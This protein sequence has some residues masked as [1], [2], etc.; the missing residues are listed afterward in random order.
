MNGYKIAIGIDRNI[1][2]FPVMVELEIPEYATVVKPNR[3]FV[4]KNFYHLVDM[5]TNT[6]KVMRVRPVDYWYVADPTNPDK[7]I[8]IK[9]NGVLEPKD[10]N[11]KG[12][13]AH[14]FCYVNK[15]VT[16]NDIFYYKEG[17]IV[18]I[19]EICLDASETCVS[20]IHFFETEKDALIYL[21]DDSN[22]FMYS[23]IEFMHNVWNNATLVYIKQV[24][25]KLSE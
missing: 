11:G 14:D 25:K 8:L 3:G 7:V 12:Y 4:T 19:D 18:S 23:A 16:G 15:V 10:W 5:R 24:L 9:S 22:E 13:S 2:P 17:D 6:A 21:V 1:G 20:G